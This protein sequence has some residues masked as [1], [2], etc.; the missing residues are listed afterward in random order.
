MN[1]VENLPSKLRQKILTGDIN[2]DDDDDDDDGLNNKVESSQ[3]WGK[4]STFWTGD[5]ADLEIGQ[6]IEDAE[7]EERAAKVNLQSSNANEFS[8]CYIDWIAF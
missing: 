6:D 3:R 7:D 2:H 8:H 5:T 1:L 4:K